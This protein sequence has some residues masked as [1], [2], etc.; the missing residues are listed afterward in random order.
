MKHDRR[1]YTIALWMATSTF[2]IHGINTAL[3]KTGWRL[4][5]W[6]G[7]GAI[8]TWFV[9]SILRD[10]RRRLFGRKVTQWL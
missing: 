7:I 9:N 3:D 5:L 6:L 4:A 8:N 1:E 10:A 2:A